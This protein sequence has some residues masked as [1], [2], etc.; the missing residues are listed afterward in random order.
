MKAICNFIFCLEMEWLMSYC[1]N[2]DY[3]DFCDFAEVYL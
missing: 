2:C 3:C 1:L